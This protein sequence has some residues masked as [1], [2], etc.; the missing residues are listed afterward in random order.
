M[1]DEL[2]MGVL[3]RFA[4]PKEEIEPIVDCVPPVVTV[5]IDRESLDELHDEER[6]AIL[7]LTSVQQPRDAWMRQRRE[8]AA[9]ALKPPGDLVGFG[10]RADEFQ[11]ALL[12][13]LPLYS[14]DEKY[15]RHSAAARFAD[16]A[17]GPDSLP[18]LEVSFRGMHAGQDGG[19]QPA[20]Y[21]AALQVRS[22]LERETEQLIDVRPQGGLSP[23][24]TVEESTSIPSVERQRVREKRVHAG[25]VTLIHDYAVATMPS[26]MGRR[27]GP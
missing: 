18:R 6:T 19:Q 25:E 7:R 17:P 20:L 26:P 13:E 14:I 15:R 1:H 2:A 23:A 3:D 9:L 24:P 5:A 21:D 4:H 11:R 16:D 12:L 8:N 10:H 22:R 27:G